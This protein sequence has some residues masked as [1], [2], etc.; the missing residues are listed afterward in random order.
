M[1]A[2]PEAIME[3]AIGQLHDHDQL[4]ANELNPFECQQEG[5]ADRFDLLEGIVFLPQLLALTY[6]FIRIAGDE[7][8]RLV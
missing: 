7:F 8:D 1:L 4:I 5:M 2:L 3:L 6:R